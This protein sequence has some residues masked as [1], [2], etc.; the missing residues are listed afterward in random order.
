MVY[1]QSHFFINGSILY[2]AI[3]IIIWKLEQ[4]THA[5]QREIFLSFYCEGNE[6]SPEKYVFRTIVDHFVSNVIVDHFSSSI[7][8]CWLK[9]VSASWA[10]L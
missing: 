1:A 5:K 9:L 6:L 3:H 7:Y 2:D 10:G 8:G 4:F